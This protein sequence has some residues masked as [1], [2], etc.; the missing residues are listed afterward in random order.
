MITEHQD[1]SPSPARAQFGRGRQHLPPN[2]QSNR[3]P[4][5]LEFALSPAES[6]V[7][8]FLI[9]TFCHPCVLRFVSS[10]APARYYFSTQPHGGER[11]SD[12]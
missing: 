3:G 5:Q 11:S 10:R 8:N 6:S 12:W 7:N 4:S 1:A 9:V 2:R